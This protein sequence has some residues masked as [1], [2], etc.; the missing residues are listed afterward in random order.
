MKKS[1]YLATALFLIAFTVNAFAQD[2]TSVSV[3]LTPGVSIINIDNNSSKFNEYRDLRDGFY[4]HNLNFNLFNQKN[5]LFLDVEA[6]K[7]LRK[8]QDALFRF[9]NVKSRWN[10]VVKYSGT[11]HQISNKARTPYIDGGNGLYTV[12]ALSGIT[13][14]GNDATG[15][16]SLVPTTAQMAINDNILGKYMSSPLL[17]P[18]K[19]G[20]QRD[21]TSVALNLPSFKGLKIGVDFMNE[22]RNGTR[23]S[24]GTI[25]DRPPRTLNVQIPDPVKYNV[26]EI[27]ANANFNKKFIQLKLDYLFSNF[28][29]KISSSRWQNLFF[30]PD[31][32][33]DYIATVAGTPRNVSNFG[34]RALAPDNYSSSI[35]FSAG[36]DLP[37]DSRFNATVALGSMKQNQELLPYSFST[38]GG[39]LLA[40]GGDGKNWNDVSKL[41]RLSTE[42]DMST[43]R[44]D[45]EYTINPVKRLNVR[46]YMR[47]YK[48]ENNMSADKWKYVTQ[49]AANTNGTVSMLNERY[50]LA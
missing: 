9:G 50:N 33:K 45:M 43:V 25:G 21:R 32:G 31:A 19:L 23:Y 49:D 6:N 35:L 29:N 26:S 2:S 30:A 1:T 14:D 48:L 36:I 17:M 22:Q 3:G 11:P 12:S 37:L 20:T 41:P 27:H 7:V 40:S 38:L 28:T 46:A 18:V 10:L 42:A 13:K 39:D 5:G 16:P 47:Y 15:T 8:D 44:F 4:L 24:Y 34:Q